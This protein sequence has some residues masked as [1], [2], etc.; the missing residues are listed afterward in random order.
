MQKSDE[1]LLKIIAEGAGKMPPNKK[2]TKDEQK[3]VL[4]YSRSLAK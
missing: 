4:Q 1:V 2:L 3:A